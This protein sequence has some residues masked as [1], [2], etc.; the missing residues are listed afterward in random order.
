MNE[1]QTES[2]GVRSVHRAFRLLSFLSHERRC[3]TLSEFSQYSGLATSTVQRLL[4]TLESERFL[5]RLADGRY[6][7]GPVLTQ[8]GLRAL[9]SMELYD[10]AQPYLD[11][12]SAGTKETANLGVWGDAGQVIYIRQ[13]LSPRSIRYVSWLGHPFPPQGSSMGLAL[14]GQCN[15]DGYVWASGNRLEPDLTGVAAPIHDPAQN[16][17]AG[18]N[19]TAPSF[20]ISDDHIAHFGGLVAEAAK[21]LTLHCGGR[22]P[23]QRYNKRVAPEKPA[24][25]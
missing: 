23:Y 21:E 9:N 7:F 10:Q 22:W 6:T 1:R 3:G 25:H 18:L 4:K 14:G 15:K 20:R 8:L 13:S 12:L 2:S 16:I 17:I 11:S 19:V 24:G 5:K